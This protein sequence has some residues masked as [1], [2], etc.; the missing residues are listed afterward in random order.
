MLPALDAILGHK[1]AH[2]F[3]T[4]PVIAEPVWKRR[5]V[6]QGPCPVTL[7]ES[8]SRNIQ[9]WLKPPRTFHL[10]FIVYYDP[11]VIFKVKKHPIF[12]SI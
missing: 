10:S 3:A 1:S 11:C 9:W 5:Q 12:S 8:P 2:S 7:L 4:G 6:R